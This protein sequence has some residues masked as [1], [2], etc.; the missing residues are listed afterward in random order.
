MPGE[1]NQRLKGNH[2]SF[3]QNS[4]PQGSTQ[5]VANTSIYPISYPYTG[6]SGFG[7]LGNLAIGDGAYAGGKTG[8]TYSSLAIGSQAAASGANSLAIGQGVSASQAQSICIGNN[9]YAN[10]T[11]CTV[12]GFQAS[13]SNN[14]ST[15]IGA[16]CTPSGQYS[17]AVGY[18]VTGVG[19]YVVGIGYNNGAAT[20]NT[21]NSTSVGALCNAGGFN[22]TCVG[23]NI[24]TITTVGG[25][26]VSVGASSNA[27]LNSIS[28]GYSNLSGS[29][30]N[31]YTDSISIGMTTYGNSG[32][33][34]ITIGNYIQGGNTGSISIGSG[35]GSTSLAALA[36][37]YQSIAIGQASKATLQGQ[38]SFG[39]DNFIGT[40]SRTS[41]L[42]VANQTTNATQTTLFLDGTT[43]SQYITLQNN[44]ISYFKAV[45]TGKITGASEA[46]VY[47][48]EGAIQKA[49]VA[50][51][52][53]LVGTPSSLTIGA[54]TGALTW[55][56]TGVA[57]TTQGSLDIKV[58][59]GASQTIDWFCKIDF[60]ELGF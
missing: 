38:F 50:A 8:G 35:V 42:R 23:Y 2:F 60:V 39:K 57:N 7:I 46:G 13:V 27:A 59:G 44:S 22:S 56:V 53:A 10:G 45:I 55:S 34:Q 47:T 48:I 14:Y 1:I 16:T 29:T 40:S 24:G 11:F 12:L 51:S 54:T 52:V 58:T 33:G 3:I 15:A 26:S 21:T 20:G 9:T 30:T 36:S 41:I 17:T 49:A 31:G 32:S 25:Y 37:A 4:Q 28:I 18:G 43:A 6:P 5:S 19:N